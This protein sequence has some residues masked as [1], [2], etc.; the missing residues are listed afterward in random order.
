MYNYQTKPIVSEEEF[1]KKFTEALDKAPLCDYVVGPGRSG[2]VAA[3]Y[4]SHYL[5]IPFVPYKHFIEGKKALVVD[6]ARA[7]GET[8]RKASRIYGDAPYVFAVDEELTGHVKFWY[9]E[10]SMARGRGNEYRRSA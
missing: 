9:E 7:S 3:V 6:T 8:L 4:A 1:R 5:G 10:L 2:A